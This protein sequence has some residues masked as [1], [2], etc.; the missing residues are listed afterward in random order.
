MCG[1]LP[2]SPSLRRKAEHVDAP[3]MQVNTLFTRSILLSSKRS[4][5]KF[6]GSYDDLTYALAEWQVGTAE[7]IIPFWLVIL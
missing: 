4:G 7:T 1:E 3:L 5:I 2:F 6:T